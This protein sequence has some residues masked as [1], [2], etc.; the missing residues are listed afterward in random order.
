MSVFEIDPDITRAETLS[1]QFYLDEKYF[2]ASKE[3]IFARCWHFLEEVIR[4][5]LVLTRNYVHLL[6]SIMNPKNWTGS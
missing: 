4:E 5:I 2:E 3:K 1:A 6:D